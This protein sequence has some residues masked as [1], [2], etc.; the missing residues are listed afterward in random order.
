[1]DAGHYTCASA[2]N[3]GYRDRQQSNTLVGQSSNSF[4][5][6][7][8]QASAKASSGNFKLSGLLRLSARYLDFK[9]YTQ[10]N[11]WA[12]DSHQS[13]SPS[14]NGINDVVYISKADVA[15]SYDTFG[16]LRIGKTRPQLLN[17]QK[18]LFQKLATFVVM[19]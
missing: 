11:E 9:F 17:Q 1:M 3:S 6:S 19:S 16:E 14:H 12:S 7:Y 18:L 15:L 2:G 13:T 10:D 5:N 4:G 8:L